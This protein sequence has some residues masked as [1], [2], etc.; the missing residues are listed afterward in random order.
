MIQIVPLNNTAEN[1]NK[2]IIHRSPGDYKM[3]AR[4][5]IHYTRFHKTE[6]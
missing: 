4:I 2:E 3:P 6:N 1:I 5:K